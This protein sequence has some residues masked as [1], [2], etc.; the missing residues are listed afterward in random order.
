ME[1]DI[2]GQ[3]S[4]EVESL[5]GTEL[6]PK[7]LSVE[8]G[9]YRLLRDF[10]TKM[11]IAIRGLD[12]LFLIAMILLS[13]GIMAASGNSGVEVASWHQLFM[14]HL[15]VVGA[16][17][18]LSFFGF[19]YLIQNARRVVAPVFA[20]AIAAVLPFVATYLLTGEIQL[21]TNALWAGSGGLA[22]AISTA[23]S[24]QVKRDFERNDG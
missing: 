7:T 17:Q 1:Q 9:F 23:V 12:A 3:F 19:C 16:V 22:V 8:D 10:E 14:A 18:V 13:W 24:T 5:Q 20:A 2:F 6:R 21:D 15:L 11:L 4:K